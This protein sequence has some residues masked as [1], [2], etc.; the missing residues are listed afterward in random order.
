MN[1]HLDI[2]TRLALAR[3]ELREQSPM[4]RL[5]RWAV[6]TTIAAFVA[7]LVL[8]FLVGSH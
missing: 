5:A 6:L 4:Q 1:E 2:R 8:G 7:G 3:F